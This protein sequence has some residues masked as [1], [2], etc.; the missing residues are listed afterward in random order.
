MKVSSEEHS[1]TADLDEH[2]VTDTACRKTL[3]GE[4][5]LRGME[6]KLN[7]RGLRVR[8]RKEANGFRF[9]NAGT[10]ISSEGALIPVTMG[11]SRLIVHIAVLPGTGQYTPFLLSKELLRGL[12]CVLDMS[13]DVPFFEK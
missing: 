8:R 13:G 7:P 2:A 10:L 3:V 4:Y 5:T 1:V 11:R 9:G 12:D 6:A